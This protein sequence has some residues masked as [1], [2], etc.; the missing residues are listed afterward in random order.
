[1]QMHSAERVE[2]SLT[3]DGLVELLRKF[4]HDVRSPLGSVIATTDMLAEGVYE[5]LTPRQMRAVERIG[6]G[7]NRTL[8]V[9]DDFMI[10][11][12]AQ[13]QQIHLTTAPFNPRA[14]LDAW[15]NQVRPAAAEKGIELVITADA[16][17]PP[18]LNG[19]ATLISRMVL[20]VLWNAIAF[21]QAG[22]VRLQSGW[23]NQQW[24][25]RITDAGAGILPQD[26]PHIFEPFWRGNERPQVT[27]AGAGLGL[28]LALALVQ[29]IGGSLT[30]EK[31]GSEGSTFCFEFPRLSVTSEM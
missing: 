10:Y 23:H 4:A 17:V 26:V 7:G 19:D 20:P 6:R 14:S 8:A 31:T 22:T 18:V 29:V 5:P 15:E 25:I 30:L 13:A 1:M 27:T 24:V 12:K 3:V 11:I 21:T 28:P 16:D 2:T 9:L